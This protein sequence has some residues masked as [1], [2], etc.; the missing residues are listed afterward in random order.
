MDDFGWRHYSFDDVHFNRPDPLSEK[1]YSISNYAFVAN[2]PI[3]FVDSD[4]REVK[5]ANN[6][7][8]NAIKNTLTT[9]D[10]AYVRLNNGII[11]KNLINQR[12]SESKNFK[13]LQILVNNDKITEFI[14]SNNFNSKDIDGN[15]KMESLGKIDN[16]SEVDVMFE[17]LGGNYQEN[18]L[19]N[20]VLAIIKK[21]LER[22]A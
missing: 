13:A 3:K 1:Y 10:A 12:Q 19:K 22:L 16:S 14:I 2:N 8:L 21:M 7:A 9:E 6:L 5:L 18:S 15:I 17:V 20:K 11:D 4:G